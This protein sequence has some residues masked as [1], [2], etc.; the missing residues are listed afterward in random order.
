MS[1][2][3]QA[4]ADRTDVRRVRVGLRQRRAA[5]ADKPEA[6]DHA[7]PQERRPASQ[8]LPTRVPS[9]QRPQISS[10]NAAPAASMPQ[11]T[12]PVADDGAQRAPDG[13]GEADAEVL[14]TAAEQEPTGLSARLIA[15]AR[16][17]QIGTA[18]SG[19][20]GF[21]KQLLADAEEVLGRAGERMRLSSSHTVV[22]LA[23]GTGSGKSSL[24]NRLAGADFSTVGVTRPVTKDAHACIW[25]A[26]G[27]GAL[28]EWLSVPARNRYSRASALGGG[29]SD[30]TGLVLLDL[31]DHDS[32]MSHA[33]ELVDRLVSRADVMIWILDPQK[34]ADAAVHR[35]FLAPLA[36]HRDVLAVVLNQS[37]L[38]SESQVDDCVTD[39]RRLLDSEGLHDAPVLVTSAVT[40]AGL[41]ELRQMLVDAVVARRAA[42]ARISA[43]VDAVVARFAP[44]GDDIDVA[45][46]EI[47][48]GS[49]E[50]LVEKFSAAAGVGAVSDA[51][52]G[53]RELRAA[54]FVGWPVGW[55]ALRLA[56]RDPLR[57]VRLGLLWHDLRSIS[58][59]PSGAQQAEI[60]NALT[61]LGDR[62]GGPLPK[63]WSQTVRAA[64]RSRADQI[65]AAIGAAMG[66]ALPADKASRRW[67]WLGDLWQGLLAGL[68]GLGAVWL[69]AIGVL[70]GFGLSTGSLQG[71]TKLSLLPAIAAGTALALLLGWLTE[72]VCMRAVRR[73]ARRE[74]TRVT[75]AMRDRIAEL[76]E[77][78][79]IMQAE[80]ELSELRR[81]R[82]EVK[83]ASQAAAGELCH[84]RVLLPVAL[85]TGRPPPGLVVHSQARSGAERVFLARQWRPRATRRATPLARQLLARRSRGCRTTPGG[86]PMFNEAQISLTGYVAT[87]PQTRTIKTTGATNLSM[88]VA[89]T[90]RY[91]DRVTG[92]WVDGSTS[93][94]TV[95]CWRKLAAYAGICLR[96][97]D[98]VIVKGRLSVR[99]YE[100]KDGI[101]RIAVEV[102]ASSV[103]HD[104]SRGVAQFARIRPQTGMSASEYAAAQADGDQPGAGPAAGADAFDDGDLAMASAGTAAGA[105]GILPDGPGEP[106]FDDA[107][108]SELAAAEDRAAVPF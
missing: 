6:A 78:M 23:G 59:G 95:I 90:P 65:P 41:G 72:T 74:V 50:Q 47:P 39:L 53:A 2:R 105:V 35:R 106:F 57:K 98:P 88:R 86:S 63:P 104:L 18:R 87:Q 56:G 27:S 31:P 5:G 44:Y 80:Q 99:P 7:D 97:G 22:V 64:A 83:V 36:G 42:A 29:E 73:A 54:D 62:L 107:A 68:A 58:A 100:G 76:A 15:L 3:R 51:L 82:D 93:Y 92:E 85:S 48:A 43:D 19:R 103:G 38:L 13:P 26:R 24:F 9:D 67:W 12:G 8:P 60:D 32:V 11:V 45:V 30:L 91:Q 108:L 34:Y 1:P 81:Y 21:S 10:R 52:R 46:V 28:L 17:I 84:P 14:G 71:L 89:W 25:G 40:G 75:A 102:E 20:D 69:A 77:S 94:V 4:T 66:E 61:D 37:D 70:H 96:K 101:S 55:L 49:R 33:T 79:V 16:M